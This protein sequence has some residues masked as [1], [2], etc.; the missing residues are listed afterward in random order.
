[1]DVVVDDSP[2]KAVLDMA[3]K[4]LTEGRSKAGCLRIPGNR[5]VGNNPVMRCDPVRSCRSPGVFG[6]GCHQLHM[7]QF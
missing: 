6:D 4:Y 2:V 7:E 3:G 1:M 5:V